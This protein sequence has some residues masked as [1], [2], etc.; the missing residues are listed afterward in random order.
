MFKGE[1]E[2]ATHKTEQPT[3]LQGLSASTLGIGDVVEFELV[4]KTNVNVPKPSRTT[5]QHEFELRLD[6]DQTAQGDERAED[7]FTH[8]EDAKQVDEKYVKKKSM[9]KSSWDFNTNPLVSV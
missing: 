5:K 8:D 4:A 2:Q 3:L 7:N 9:K 1:T 6:T